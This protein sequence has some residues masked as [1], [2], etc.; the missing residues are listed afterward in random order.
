MF[1]NNVLTDLTNPSEDQRRGD[2]SA[3]IESQKIINP[4]TGESVV[5]FSKIR[6]RNQRAGETVASSHLA[7]DIETQNE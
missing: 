2:L 7:S 6:H 5:S 4:F 3:V 1:T